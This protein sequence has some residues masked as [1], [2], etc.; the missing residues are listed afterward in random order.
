MTAGT[1]TVYREA[2]VRSALDLT[3]VIDAVEAAVAAEA[4]GT[5]RNIAKT[6][7]TWDPASSAHALGAVDRTDDLVAFKSWVNTPGGAAA[8]VTVFDAADG[9]LLAAVEAGALGALRTAA[10]SGVATRWLAAPG[11]D[12]LAVAGTG[13]QALRQVQAVTL[14]R[15][16]HEV[17]VWS[18]DAGHRAAFAARVADELGIAATAASSLPEAV[19]GAG[20]VTLV[21]RATQPFLGAEHVPAHAHV[22]AVGAILPANAEFDPA[23]L[24]GVQLAVVDNLANA[25]S[26]SRE[27]REHYGEDWSTV[28]TLGEIVT[29]KAE[30]SQSDAR[31]TLFKGLGMGLADLAAVTAFLRIVEP[32]RFNRS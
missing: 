13:R 6:M 14:V 16:V 25:R 28:H 30:R 9:R 11:A 7:T 31:P 17:R 10:V 21:T 24:A 4:A 2:D 20:I 12:T 29:G 22:N 15:P 8:I 32:D 18:R 26:S 27:L 23:L 19:A 1:G 5:A 3:T